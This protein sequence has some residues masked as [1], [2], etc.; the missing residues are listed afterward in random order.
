MH[1][2]I[3]YNFTYFSIGD[4]T[5]DAYAV[6]LFIK[7]DHK[8]DLDLSFLKKMCLYGM[9]KKKYIIYIYK[10]FIYIYIYIYIY[11]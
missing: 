3:F 5:R 2:N 7:K 9:Y 4:F 11:I 1:S 8:I 6:R 10:N